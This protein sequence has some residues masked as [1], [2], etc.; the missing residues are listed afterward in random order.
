MLTRLYKIVIP[1][2]IEVV[3]V[4]VVLL[5]RQWTVWYLSVISAVW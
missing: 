4:D 1:A 3:A 5:C 2:V